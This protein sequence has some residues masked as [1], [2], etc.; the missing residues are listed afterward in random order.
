MSDDAPEPEEIDLGDWPDAVDAYSHAYNL[1]R[2]AVR[3][4]AMI[5]GDGPDPARELA[6]FRARLALRGLD[7][8][9]EARICA[10]IDRGEV[11]GRAGVE[12]RW[13]GAPRGRTW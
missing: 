11:D 3:D 13:G 1:A 5:R 8:A 7:P 12:R 9:D 2:A 4:A 6:T 10:A